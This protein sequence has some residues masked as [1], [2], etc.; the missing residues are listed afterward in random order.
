[1]LLALKR[2]VDDD[3]APGR[4]LVTGSANILTLPRVADSLAGRMETI[5]L[6]PLARSE[7]LGGRPTFL[8]EAF[9]GRLP[10]PVGSALGPDLIR[11][12]V[13]GGFPEAVA[14]TSERR[15]Q[16]WARAYLNSVL[17]RD[18]RDIA[19]IEKL[20]DLPRFVRALAQY[21]SNLVNYSE[22]AGAIGVDRKTAQRYV[23]LLEQIFLIATIR[24]WHSNELSRIIK[25]PKLHFLRTRGCSQLHAALPPLG[26]A[27]TAA[28]WL[29][30]WRH[31]SSRRS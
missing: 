18:L 22:V 14:R 1:M 30:R 12:V 9:T 25:T 24:P 6:L 11:L 19:V 10:R 28:C 26:S 15:R 21:S 8:D 7:I 3:L 29:G 5:R 27:P 17:L 4:F 16:G 20:T 13:E 31:S 2:A 23:S